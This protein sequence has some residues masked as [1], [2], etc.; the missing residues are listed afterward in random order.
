MTLEEY[1][2]DALTT[3]QTLWG[4]LATMI[5][6]GVFALFGWWL[7]HRFHPAPFT[8]SFVT[9]AIS[10]AGT[11]LVVVAALVLLGWWLIDDHRRTHDDENTSRRPRWRVLL[12]YLVSY[13][14]PAALVLTTTAIPLAST[15]LYL[16]GVRVDQSF[17]SQF[18]TRMA[19]D[20]H[21]VDM[22]YLDLPSYYPLGWFWLGGR[23]AAILHMPGWQVF[24]P[25]A[26]ISIAMAASTLVP[27]WQRIC[28]SLPVATAIA[29]VSVCVILVMTPAEPYAAVIA[30][31]VPAAALLTQRAMN[32]SWLSTIAVA[33][34]L[35]I[36]ANF[37]TLYTA[38]VAL[39]SVAVAGIVALLVRRDWVP[40]IHLVVIG[41]GSAI[42][43][44]ISW[45]P[46]LWMKHTS[47]ITPETTAAK[48]LPF[49]GTQIPVPFLSLSIVGLLCLVGLIYLVVRIADADVRSMTIFTVVVYLWSV[50]SMVAT[51]AGTTLLGFRVDVLIV[52]LLATAGVLAFA[53]LPL[54]GIPRLYPNRISD[55]LGKRIAVVIVVLLGLVGIRYAQQIPTRNEMVI[56][57]AY[58]DTDFYG[59]RADNLQPDSASY[60]REINDE[61]ASHGHTPSDTVVVVDEYPFLA[62]TPYHGF[63][64]ATSNYANPLGEYSQ[65][66]KAIERWA[67]ESWSSNSTPQEFSQTIHSE[68][69]RGPDAFIFRGS[70][71]DFGP[72]WQTH[73]AEDVYPSQPNVFFKPVFFNPAVFENT[74]LW[75][76]KQVGPYVVVTS[77][78]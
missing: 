46:Y 48:Y 70:V 75:A 24:Q 62:F 50:A 44:L 72:G 23:L 77:T 34:F 51:I 78:R 33:L 59:T 17:R 31:G 68:K 14:A 4:I 64:A 1:D 20:W 2:S 25:W 69:W 76:V 18:L 32:G 73:V 27:V 49:E 7:I 10:S 42:L 65:R 55:S 43:A 8:T 41:V 19:T 28:K 6:S 66:V 58:Q 22:N 61:I 56:D 26:L 63:N 53:E 52:I 60:Y 9:R 39:S 67:A 40:V 35:G 54:Y 45:G 15:T 21:D 36:A 71:K 38:V 3:R 11:V 12:T 37:Y 13:L 47:G 16:D 57:H 29:L 30:L 74:D 5:G